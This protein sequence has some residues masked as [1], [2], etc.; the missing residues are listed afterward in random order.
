LPKYPSY[1][2]TAWEAEDFDGIEIWNQMSE[3]MEKLT[4]FNQLKMV[5][6]PR[7]VLDSPTERILKKWDEL[8]KKR[9]VVGIGGVDVHAHPYKIGPFRIIIF[10][11]KVQFKSLR[12]HVL[13][14]EPMSSDFKKAKDQIF[15][16]L[17]N[18]NVFAS[19]Y[20][21]G[22]AKGF[23]FYA[24]AQNKIFKIGEKIGFGNRIKLII[25]TPHVSQIRLLCD[26]VPVAQTRGKELEHA[27]EVKGSYRVEAYRKKRGWIFSN[28]IRV[29]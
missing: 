7:R 14:N 13:L 4:K 2:W 25:K 8:N 6:S 26:G 19:N 29:L 3:W 11:Y 22:D 24:Q 27:P 5:L 16:G 21:W 18:C 1:P 12:T 10:P 9:K 23:A 20:R 15:F 17:R 28:H